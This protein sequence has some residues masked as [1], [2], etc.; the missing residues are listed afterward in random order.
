MKAR[1]NTKVIVV[2][3]DHHNT[4]AVIR[5]LGRTGCE[6]EALIHTTFKNVEE[7][8]ISKSKYITGKASCVEEDETAIL[9]RLLERATEEKQ[10][11]FLS[12][13]KYN[14]ISLL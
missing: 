11:L 5:C 3:G 1:L 7:L 12:Q 4:L 6:Q 8:K 13:E 2:G 10:I 9:N 14:F